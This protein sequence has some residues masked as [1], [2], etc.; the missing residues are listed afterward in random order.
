MTEEHVTI[1]CSICDHKFDKETSLTL[2]PVDKL[3]DYFICSICSTK[4]YK[5]ANPDDQEN[6]PYVYD[7]DFVE[8]KEE[9]RNGNRHSQ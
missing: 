2:K 9:I 3:S 8:W 7:Y 4:I 1:K 5:I 6:F